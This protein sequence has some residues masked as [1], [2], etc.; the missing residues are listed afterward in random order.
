MS[1]F[2]ASFGM[3][4]GLRMTRFSAAAVILGCLAYLSSFPAMA[5]SDFGQCFPWQEFRDG[6]CVAKPSQAPPLLPDPGPPSAASP[7]FDGMRSL[8]GQCTCPINAHPESGRCVADAAPA[9]PLPTAVNPPVANAA[10]A[11]PLPAAVSPP[12][13][14]P[15]PPPLPTR[16]ADEPVICDGGTASGGSCVCPGGYIVMPPRG[17]GGGGTCVRTDAENCQGGELTVSGTC[18]CN[19]Q[20]IMSGETYLLEYTHGKCVPKRCPVSTEM[21]GG[22]CISV[23]AVA[24]APEPEP[25]AEPKARSKEN[26]DA[27]EG[28]HHHGC[29]RGM[30]RTHSGCVVARRKMPVIAPPIGLPQYYRTYEFPGNSS[31]NRPN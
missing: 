10:S 9:P 8:S 16:K 3:A 25:K 30:V 22:K 27:D 17:G 13:P 21:R 23:S 12:V 18:M 11:P 7:C 29:G 5:Q 31:V 20:V 26:K 1:L 15:L 19:G 14:P 28:E 6:R 24:P 2:F 4:R